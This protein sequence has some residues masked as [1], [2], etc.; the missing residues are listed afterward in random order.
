M[1]DKAGVIELLNQARASELTA[2][3]QYMAH[4]YE[5]EDRH[6]RG[7]AARTKAIAIE[8]MKHAERLA[9]RIL[10]LGGTPT[11]KPDGTV[12]TGQAIPELLETDRRLEQ[13]TCET[14]GRFANECSES[15]DQISRR[16]F[17][18]LL[19]EEER[20]LKS[21]RNTGRHVKKRG[22]SHLARLAGSDGG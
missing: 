19:E 17:D 12:R 10:F 21:F 13:Q 6:Y 16:L 3:A 15:G 7:L 9:Q 2:I 5:L 8:E 11:T 1:K 4:H 18:A 14:Y 20:H 22:A